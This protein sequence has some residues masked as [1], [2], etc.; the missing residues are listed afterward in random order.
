MNPVFVRTSLRILGAVFTALG[1]VEHLTWQT[2]LTAL[3]TFLVG[4]VTTAPNHVAIDSLPP[5]VQESV[6]PPP[7]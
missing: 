2:A 7:P 1:A 6:R 4:Y 5:E 3:G